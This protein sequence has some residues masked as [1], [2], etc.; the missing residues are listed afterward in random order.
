MLYHSHVIFR[1]IVRVCSLARYILDLHVIQIL[2]P[3][4]A[5][6]LLPTG[7]F[8]RPGQSV[9]DKFQTVM[10]RGFMVGLG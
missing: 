5:Q 3:P 1:S 10:T 8:P 9:K 2:T 6:P 7:R 4:P